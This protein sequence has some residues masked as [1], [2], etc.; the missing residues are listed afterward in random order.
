MSQ[1]AFFQEIHQ[2]FDKDATQIIRLYENKKY[3]EI[4]WTAGPLT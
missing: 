4:E 1:G 3:I 2:V